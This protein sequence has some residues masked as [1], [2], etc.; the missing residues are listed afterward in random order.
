M[1]SPSKPSMITEIVIFRLKD[2][3]DPD[4]FLAEAA[5]TQTFA[6]SQPGFLNRKL[7]RGEDGKQWVDIV[8]WQSLEE[9]NKAGEAYLVSPSCAK[10]NAMIDEQDIQMMHLEEMTIP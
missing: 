5:N 8:R 6:S 1:T 4:Q 3:A 7:H 10:F 2:G 9:A